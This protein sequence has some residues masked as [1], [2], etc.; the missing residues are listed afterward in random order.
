MK[1]MLFVLITLLSYLE[2]N[3]QNEFK[4]NVA[5][6]E[7]GGAGLMVSL[8]YEHQFTQKPGFGLRG[9]IGLLKKETFY[10][11]IPVGIVYLSQVGRSSYL[12]VGFTATYCDAEV[13]LYAIVEHRFNKP[14]TY[15]KIN[16]IPSIGWREQNRKNLMMRYNFTPVI[17]QIGF[18]PY[19]GLSIGKTF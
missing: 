5:H 10:F 7:L 4:R 9:G 16:Y 19:M 13:N 8:N 15:S 11:T 12:D 18:L 14:V 17:N 1:T 6:F 3:T 2:G